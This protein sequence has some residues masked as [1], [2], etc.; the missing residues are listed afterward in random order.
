MSS[1]LALLK[2]WFNGSRDYHK[3]VLLFCSLSE[4]QELKAFFLNNA[5]EYTRRRLS[6]EMEKLY[7]AMKRPTPAEEQPV[8]PPAP[9]APLPP[10]PPKN[11]ALE[12]ACDQKALQLY[13]QM[14]N[15]RAILFNL[16]KVEG[17]DDV[18]KPDLVEQRRVLALRVI[19]T[20]Y[21]V[22]QAYDDLAYV[23]EHGNLPEY[24]QPET[25]SEISDIEL[26]SAIANLRAN[27]TKL[28]KRAQTPERV[29]LIQKH[30][31]KLLELEDRWKQIKPA[32]E[33]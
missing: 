9:I 31:T 32:H 27:L 20:N 4:D 1:M 25:A 18:N 14:M 3:G 29:T 33:S 2:I 30:Q 22:S 23:R 28:R 15:D 7:N 8:P 6:E 17:W 11:P 21:E 10:D 16:T 5:S 19:S 26:R 12:V 24:V 13:K